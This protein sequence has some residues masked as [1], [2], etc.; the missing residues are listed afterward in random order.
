MDPHESPQE[1][2][3]REVK[4]ETGLEISSPILGGVMV[5]SSPVKY[6]WIS[7]IFSTH[8]DWTEPPTSNEGVLKWIHEGQLESTPIPK[9]DLYIYRKVLAKEFFFLDVNYDKDLNIKEMSDHHFV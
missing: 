3:I 2:V 9:T 8:I 6:N 5:E 7:F 1:T 4:E